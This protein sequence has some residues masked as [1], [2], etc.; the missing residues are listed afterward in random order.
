MA[1]GPGFGLQPAETQTT[2]EAD[3]ALQD[4]QGMQEQAGA[5]VGETVQ[6]TPTPQTRPD[7][8]GNL[9]PQELP[10]GGQALFQTPD[11]LSTQYV[12]PGQRPSPALVARPEGQLA[13]AQ[14]GW[15][16][17]PPLP[18]PIDFEK[19]P[20]V[21]IGQA[22]GGRRDA[23]MASPAARCL[24]MAL[25][26]FNKGGKQVQI[27][28]PNSTFRSAAQQEDMKAA[29]GDLAASP[30]TS[31][32]EYG[33][34]VDVTELTPGALAKFDKTMAKYGF[35]RYDPEGKEGE[36]HHYS[37]QPGV[38]EWSKE[39]V[40]KDDD[41]RMTAWMK[42]TGYKGVTDK[43]EQ[44]R[45]V[46]A[47]H[48]F[49]PKG[50]ALINRM[51]LQESGME[52]NN[53]DGSLKTS[54]AGAS[55]IGQMMPD[56]LAPYLRQLYPDLS[57][58]ERL[59][60]Y[61]GSEAIQA[62]IA[63]R[64]LK[65]LVNRYQG[66]MAKALAAYN[67]GPGAVDHA[68]QNGKFPYSESKDSWYAQTLP[69][70]ANILDVDTDTAMKWIAGKDLP[71]AESDRTPFIETSYTDDEYK[72]EQE[73]QQNARDQMAA[74]E[75]MDVDPTAISAGQ[76]MYDFF[77]DEHAAGV[78]AKIASG[79][80][81][82]ALEVRWN[83]TK[84]GIKNTALGLVSALAF[85]AD[86]GL[87]LGENAVMGPSPPGAK[88][89]FGF[90][91]QEFL[92]EHIPKSTWN[93]D[94]RAQIDQD[95]G[96][97]NFLQWTKAVVTGKQ[98]V[99]ADAVK[100][101]IASLG[102][103]VPFLAGSMM[104]SVLTGPSGLLAEGGPLSRAGSVGEKLRAGTLDALAKPDVISPLI[105]KVNSITRSLGWK[106]IPAGAG[107][108]MTVW[109]SLGT[110]WG[111]GEG[112]A[113]M[114]RDGAEPG[115]PQAMFGMV[116]GGVMGWVTGLGLSPL[117]IG[118]KGTAG[119]AAKAIQE[120]VA[121]GGP[122]L[123]SHVKR[124]YS[125]SAAAMFQS[126]AEK[127]PWLVSTMEKAALQGHKLGRQLQIE[128]GL[129]NTA[130]ELSQL[131]GSYR[132]AAQERQRV[133]D[134]AY[135]EATSAR[136]AEDA[137]KQAVEAYG[138]LGRATPQQKAAVDKLLS[139]GVEV[140]GVL[141]RRDKLEQ[142]LANR[143]MYQQKEQ[144]A[145]EII[146]RLGAIQKDPQSAGAK[147]GALVQERAREFQALG[148]DPA[149][150]GSVTELQNAL[151][152][153]KGEAARK[154]RDVLDKTGIKVPELEQY[155]E[156]LGALAEAK[157]RRQRAE[158]NPAFKDAPAFTRTV[159]HY[160]SVADVLDQQSQYI[161]EN[162]VDLIRKVPSY[163]GA[164][165]PLPVTAPR[166]AMLQRA[167][168]LK[169]AAEAMSRYKGQDPVIE[170]Y[171]DAS[172][173][174]WTRYLDEYVNG[175]PFAFSTKNQVSAATA[176]MTRTVLAAERVDPVTQE[177][178]YLGWLSREI[179]S[180]SAEIN[181]ARLDGDTEKMATLKSQR[182]KLEAERASFG[183]SYGVQ[184]FMSDGTREASTGYTLQG[185]D[186]INK[187]YAERALRKTIGDYPGMLR[188]VDPT[189]VGMGSVPGMGWMANPA[190]KVGKTAG[191]VME[192]HPLLE[193]VHAMRSLEPAQRFGRFVA[194]IVG[195]NESLL[196][197]A[198]PSRVQLRDIGADPNAGMNADAHFT[199]PDLFEKLF[200]MPEAQNI[201]NMFSADLIEKF[202]ADELQKANAADYI[203]KDTE[204]VIKSVDVFGRFKAE[205][206]NYL[207]LKF[208]SS[209][210]AVIRRAENPFRNMVHMKASGRVVANNAQKMV[211]N[212]IAGLPAAYRKAT[213]LLAGAGRRKLKDEIGHE[214][215]FA[216]D[217]YTRDQGASLK[218][219]VKDKPEL[220]P[221]AESYFS[222]LRVMEQIK[223][224]SPELSSHF[225]RGVFFHAFPDLKDH[226][227]AAR[228]MEGKVG[229]GTNLGSEKRRFLSDLQAAREMTTQ[230]FDKIGRTEANDPMSRVLQRPPSTPGARKAAFLGM[231]DSQQRMVLGMKPTGP[232]TQTER[233]LVDQ[234]NLGLLVEKIE[235][236]PARVIRNQLDSM[237]TADAQRTA[238]SQLMDLQVPDTM[239]TDG[240]PVRALM[241]ISEGNIPDVPV[242]NVE[243][244]TLLSTSDR[245]AAL[246][247]IPS[248]IPPEAR[249]REEGII[250]QQAETPR[251][252]MVRLSDSKA[253]DLPKGS[254]LRI[255][256]KDFNADELYI[257]PD[258]LDHYLTNHKPSVASDAAYDSEALATLVR[259]GQ[260]WGSPM[261]HTWNLTFSQWSRLT[262]Q[263]VGS[264]MHSFNQMATSL[265]RDSG[266]PFSEGFKN[267][268]EGTKDFFRAVTGV[269]VVGQ[270]AFGN[271]ILQNQA[272]I[273]PGVLVQDMVSH[274]VDL[275][276]WHSA[277]ESGQQEVISLIQREGLPFETP[278]S[279]W[280][281]MVQTDPHYTDP[282]VE[283][284][285]SINQNMLHD[286]PKGMALDALTGVVQAGMQT[287]YHM[288]NLM[289]FEPIKQ[290][291]VGGY[292]HSV[293]AHWK[294]RGNALLKQGYTP[295]EAM[296]MVKTEVAD[297]FNAS[298][299]AV[300]QYN[301]MK[302]F[303]ADVTEMAYKGPLPGKNKAEAGVNA[304]FS[305]LT[306]GWWRAKMEPLF[307]SQ[308]GRKALDPRTW[309]GGEAVGEA[310]RARTRQFHYQSP[311][312]AAWA[313][314]DA[315]KGM[316]IGMS[317]ALVAGKMFEYFVHGTGELAKAITGGKDDPANR[318]MVD[319]PNWLTDIRVGP[320][321]TMTNPAFGV[322]KQIAGLAQKT[323]DSSGKVRVKPGEIFRSLTYDQ[324]QDPGKKTI[325]WIGSVTGAGKY[326]HPFREVTD[327][328]SA[329]QFAQDIG[330]HYLKN[331]V[332]QPIKETL[333]YESD[334]EMF[335]NRV[336]NSQYVAGLL[337][338]QVSDY[339]VDQKVAAQLRKVVE[340]QA[341]AHQRELDKET[342]LFTRAIRDTNDPKAR[343]AASQ[344]FMDYLMKEHEL[345]GTTP[346]TEP[347]KGLFPRGKYV[348]GKDRIRS[349]YA[350]AI[351]PMG[352][353][354]DTLPKEMKMPFIKSTED[355]NWDL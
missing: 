129:Q 228:F 76:A 148:V 322:Y 246:R 66:N 212:V 194:D 165:N 236:N 94:V 78:E 337:G 265:N 307:Q 203:A 99:T 334:N 309:W 108:E 97:K 11:N 143:K 46:S 68:E 67:G 58:E 147:M 327:S 90:G 115:S 123:A 38:P 191:L 153:A 223:V 205:T 59:K 61:Q 128:V 138:T 156:A 252:R 39:R 158:S 3:Q 345:V 263:A 32:H 35:A 40:W 6:A 54:W 79:Q 231:S 200:N 235:V 305:A 95:R 208:P 75:G 31:N 102:L 241:H 281:K 320:R 160:H 51:F 103:E 127:A 326:V 134:T 301:R 328:D 217:N 297:K 341:K 286:N 340:D 333:G 255:N 71:A 258:V 30:G 338:F 9:L 50:Q 276:L 172:I 166:E 270:A 331:S 101:N 287:E 226:R 48:G 300:Q 209:A 169:D 280:Q 225:R 321:S 89:T 192:A 294:M 20:I 7:T 351:E 91:L 229:I 329:L 64:H 112:H 114:I 285:K 317:A 232:L 133:I 335:A 171:V 306:P 184:G 312:Y 132:M 314:N 122:L 34:A 49:S 86:A 247:E 87:E 118:A 315:K 19:E 175:R 284:L 243:G 168:G 12:E 83:D 214:L 53:K 167:T 336:P 23:K 354:L 45:R 253:F 27:T 5:A 293:A 268:G 237:F 14:E 185:R 104:S 62:D 238:L 140:P 43:K 298:S 257:H 33:F 233:D 248:D 13:P 57:P 164:D 303:G 330:Q 146:K 150:S 324:L 29:Y 288:N 242:R 289:T 325:D 346:K 131:S 111:M 271:R 291:L 179:K 65:T 266:T 80:A 282:M 355:R 159:G 60:L 204:E 149:K 21:Y 207:D 302:V 116:A 313:R 239:W 275:R 10:Q 121:E 16:A 342:T 202:R 350:K 224:I 124:F 77:T 304:L 274:G 37:W 152:K 125:P 197:L 311:E 96:G 74:M 117:T 17:P 273:D 210:F 135:K 42:N 52:G 180:T 98:D 196:D 161:N 353:T 221:V 259:A 63:V 136:E 1:L 55:G 254:T 139:Q 283:T 234:V 82:S 349:I 272:G 107:R 174:Q 162:F 249:A 267:L 206:E 199:D 230:A 186:L 222:L 292:Y 81:A 245:K 105:D 41:P 201:D 93:D 142:V 24:Q 70:V 28:G 240:K 170:A 323:F 72:N 2:P 56:T 141:S 120:R 264:I 256:N 244:K 278:T 100:A 269:D 250:N 308:N 8:L 339:N 195:A 113:A 178:D 198:S 187:V 188:A 251:A 277:M 347:Y 189:W 4:I 227:L 279:R 163:L 145:N 84:E 109:Q 155:Q 173:D 183:D 119:A 18:K 319:N 216:I 15:V 332:G 344:K 69:Y 47:S 290:A 181:R 219:L 343:L 296:R 261:F 299:G 44:L 215:S 157:K 106:G 36:A 154:Y 144:A 262:S 130:K 310:A 126:L 110:L 25:N 176:E 295:R 348:L 151:E 318:E 193:A 316:L 218:Q 137:A 26:E 352:Y 213:G 177:K 88:D 85:M 73:F 190:F 92:N 22:A 260:L 220:K 211:E 182:E